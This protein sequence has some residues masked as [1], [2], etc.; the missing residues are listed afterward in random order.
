VTAADISAGRIRVPSSAK[1]VFPDARAD[2]A[3]TLRGVEMDVRWH[4]HYNPDQERSGV[5]SIGAQR[6]AS[7]VEPEEVLTVSASNRR[8]A[9]A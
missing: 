7:L 1:S 8:V 4:P 2:V 3:I 5:L 6:L 9:L